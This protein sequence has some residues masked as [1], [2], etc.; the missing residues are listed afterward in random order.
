MAIITESTD[1]AAGM[2][3]VYSMQTGDIFYGTNPDPDHD[4]IA[5]Y[6]EPGYNYRFTLMPFVISDHYIDIRDAEGDEVGTFTTAAY[7]LSPE[8]DVAGTYYIDIFGLEP[9]MDDGGYD[10]YYVRMEEGARKRVDGTSGRDALP[11]GTGQDAIRGYKG[12]DTLIGGDGDDWL[13]GGKGPDRIEGGAGWDMMRGGFG[14]DVFVFKQDDRVEGYI[15]DFRH[16]EDDKINLR[17]IDAK[18][19]KAKNNAFT[20]IGT[21]DFSGRQGELR[22]DPESRDTHVYADTDG[23]GDYDFTITLKGRLDLNAD[24]FVL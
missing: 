5:V 18:Q 10:Q 1:A 15:H 8:I 20:F 12:K 11:G 19:H 14:R 22:F 7:I 23:D 21:D 4:W 17:W 13:Q 6:L 16:S 9:I 24:D 3:T 2:D